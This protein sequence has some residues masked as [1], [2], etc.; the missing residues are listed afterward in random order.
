[1]YVLEDTG[2]SGGGGGTTDYSE[3]TDKPTINGVELDGN[4][5][6][7]DLGVATSQQGVKADTAYQKPS[8]GIPESDL[9]SDVQQALQKHFKGWY[10][11]SS[12]LPANPVIGDYAYV[13]GA[14]TTDPAAIYE[15]TTD[16]SWSDSGRTADTSNVQTFATGEHVN[17]VGI[18]DEPT[19]E[20]DNLVKSGGVHDA[21]ESSKSEFL[22]DEDGFHVIDDNLNVGMKYD[23]D[24]LDVA[25]VTSHFVEVLKASGISADDV[26]SSHASLT[27]EDGF[28]I[29]DEELNIGVKVDSDGIHAKNILEYEIVEN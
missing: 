23:E 20:S 24:G 21:I 9:S 8:S 13:K 10:D 4:K 12:N 7:S 16:G 17:E 14:E 28:F 25:K 22:V 27:N 11:S 29:A 15:C 3:L 18:D 5:T 6:S 2:G 1:M 19:A 26:M